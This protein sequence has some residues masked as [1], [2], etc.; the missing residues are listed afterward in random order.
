MN[1]KSFSWEIV[2]AGIILT[3]IAIYFMKSGG[4][5]NSSNSRNTNKAIP[6]DSTL[7]QNESNLVSHP[8]NLSDLNKLDSL[9]TNKNV[10]SL[11][12]DLPNFNKTIKINSE[13]SSKDTT[14]NLVD[15]VNSVI[16]GMTGLINKQVTIAF[17]KN[18]LFLHSQSSK[19]ALITRTYSDAVI[20]NLA[21]HTPGGSIE[22]QGYNGHKIIIGI[23]SNKN[24]TKD[25]FN[26]YYKIHFSKKGKKL[27]INIS[28]KDNSYSFL[29]FFEKDSKPANFDV[30]IPENLSFQASS[31]GGT[32]KAS[33]LL[34][35]IHL[36]TAGGVIELDHLHGNINAKT[37]GGLIHADHMAGNISLNTS[38]GGI[39]VANI[40]GILNLST[41]GG[42]INLKSV[43]GIIKGHTSAG[44]IKA[45]IIKL[46][47][48]LS[49]ST[50][51]G[52]IYIHI[53]EKSP[54][55]LN[56]SGTRVFV[57]E[58]IKVSGSIGE[59]RIN[60]TINGG[61]ASTIQAHTSIGNVKID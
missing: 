35:T 22:A 45:D 11:I 58:N 18:A 20:K 33:G 1:S 34:K 47:N 5:R 15:K 28:K 54:A 37:S 39:Q 43:E 42:N 19:K 2:I 32:L 52:N 24:V 8:V 40:S 29:K 27:S 49:L 7:V 25:E 55:H 57:N 51:A 9:I 56:L 4:I 3:V 46:T 38:G 6:S 41:S 26:K 59:D 44:N 23:G 60:G 10:D 16:T 61:G 13:N 12:I 14:H 31:D 21:L 53:P 30:K 50:S 48:N 36:T 17:E